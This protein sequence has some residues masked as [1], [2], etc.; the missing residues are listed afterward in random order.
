MAATSAAQT[1]ASLHPDLEKIASRQA[2][3]T[4]PHD[5]QL[6]GEADAE[7]LGMLWKSIGLWLWL[8]EP[9]SQ[10]GIQAGT[11]AQLYYD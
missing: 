6:A 2:H 4:V 1:G 10:A 3:S 9:H 7:L 5:D 11:S 8:I